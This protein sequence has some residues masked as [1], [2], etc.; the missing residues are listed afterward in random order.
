MSVEQIEA[1]IEIKM[2]FE[3]AD[4]IRNGRAEGHT[5]NWSYYP[6]NFSLKVWVGGDNPNREHSKVDSE[7]NYHGMTGCIDSGGTIYPRTN[8]ARLG[9]NY[10]EAIEN[11]LRKFLGI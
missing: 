10:F 4:G 8:T 3:Q 5:I 9:E 11:K 2:P 6:D 1:V 7:G